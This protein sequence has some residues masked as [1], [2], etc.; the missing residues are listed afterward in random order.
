MIVTLLKLTVGLYELKMIQSDTNQDPRRKTKDDLTGDAL[1]EYDANN[2]AMNLILISIPNDIYNSVDSYYDDE[3]QGKTFQNDPEDHITSA[4]ML[5]A[6]AIT[7]YYSTPTNNLLRSF[8]NTRNQAVTQVNR[9]D[10]Q[11]RNFGN[12]EDSSIT[13]KEDLDDLFG[14]MYEE[15]F[16]KRSLEV[17]ISFVAQ[18]T[19]NN[20]NTPSSSSIIV[21]DNEA[22][23]LVSSSEEQ[24]S[25][26]SNDE[27]DEL[28]QE[29]DSTDLDRN[30]LLYPYHTTMFKEVE[31]SSTAEDSS[32]MQ[33]IT[34]VQP[35]THI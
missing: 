24:I 13:T 6:H 17:S 8:P 34:P 23:P 27:V 14:L 15:Y 7:Q 11:S 31:S 2:E 9:V 33:G 22:S 12:D 25:S 4:M 19:I 10:I 32:N 28:I 26:F 30:T 1:K 3:Y 16:K 5:L 29:E 18:T 20:Q 35:S 21:E